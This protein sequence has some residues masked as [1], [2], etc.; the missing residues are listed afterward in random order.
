[1]RH[2]SEADYVPALRFNWLTPYYDV[3][4]GATTRA[5]AFKQAL[6]QEADIQAGHR[7]LDLAPGTGTLA[8]WAKQNQP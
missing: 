4:V 7:V 5:C 2:F 6:I 8:I 1:M 3:G